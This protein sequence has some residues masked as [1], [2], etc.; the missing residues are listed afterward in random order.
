MYFNNI[1]L[2][3]LLYKI[4]TIGCVCVCVYANYYNKKVKKRET[5]LFHYLK[6]NKKK[7]FNK[8]I[9]LKNTK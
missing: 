6:Q 9:E 4:R 5:C 3:T 2:F 1:Y 7:H 8:E